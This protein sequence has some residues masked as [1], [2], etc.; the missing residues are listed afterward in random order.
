MTKTVYLNLQS[1]E[2]FFKDQTLSANW[3]LSWYKCY[4]CQW[5]LVTVRRAM[6]RLCRISKNSI[7]HF[8]ISVMSSTWSSW[9]GSVWHKKRGMSVH[10]QDKTELSTCS[11]LLANHQ[12]PVPVPVCSLTNPINQEVQGH[13]PALSHHHNPPFFV[14]F[15]FSFWIMI[16]FH[17][18]QH[19]SG[20]HHIPWLG[21]AKSG[22][23]FLRS[24]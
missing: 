18:S 11:S 1:T 21:L 13:L 7:A 17:G 3:G 15:L 12:V 5:S 24:N 23:N 20:L 9:S 14:I 22:H 6:L 8:L 2:Y 10:R 16:C 4:F 19:S